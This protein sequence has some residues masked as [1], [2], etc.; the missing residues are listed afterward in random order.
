MKIKN[1]LVSAVALATLAACAGVK[2]GDNVAPTKQK[3]AFFTTRSDV[4]VENAGSFK[5]NKKIAIPVFRV[6][7][8]STAGAKS[9]A[10]GGIGGSGA[11]VKANTKMIGMKDG[12][13]Q[14]VAES[15]YKNFVSDLKAA[16]YEVVSASAVKATAGYKELKKHANGKELNGM[17]YYAPSEL[18]V[19]MLPGEEGVLSG[20]NAI[21]DNKAY[22]SIMKELGASVANVTLNVDYLT[23]NADSGYFQMSA[24]FEIGAVLSVR[25]GSG[26]HFYS[27]KDLDCVGYCTNGWGKI[28]L[29]QA[30][31]SQE[32]FGELTDITSDASAAGQYALAMVSHFA[33]VKKNSWREFELRVDSDKFERIT[34]D[35]TNK[36]NKAI[37]AK[38]SEAK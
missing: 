4:V 28:N 38:W 24:G 36:T 33:G 20:F 14:R 9:D 34:K 19:V 23:N 35:L 2:V 25:P 15:A 17:L 37:I 31:Y 6:G 3:G 11:S 26:V 22:T 27:F 18:E 1:I 7:F 21:G 12:V 8:A 32:K 10:G 13:Y 16:G 5:G 29:G 30:I